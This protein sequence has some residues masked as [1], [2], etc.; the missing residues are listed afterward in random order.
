MAARCVMVL[1]TS[2]GAGKSFL[3]TALC[4]WYANQGL[5]VAPFKAQNMSNNARVVVGRGGEPGEIGAAQYFQALAAGAEPEVRMNPVLLKPE[6]D[7]RSQV[8]VLGRVRSELAAVPWR[9]RSAQLWPAALQALQSLRADHEVVVIEGA[10][11]PAEINLAA[12]DFV[13]TRTARAAQ[14]ACLLV[15]DIDRG[16]AFAHCFGTHA[17]MDAAVRQ[18]LRGFVLNKFRGDASLL[19]PAPQRLQELTGL[20]T[21]AVLPMQRDHGLPEED[22]LHEH[23]PAPAA[24]SACTVAVV[25]PPSASNLDEFQP[26]R[27][28]PGVR[29]VWARDAAAA[30]ADWLVLPGSKHTRADL[31]WL[32]E[33]GLDRAIAAHVQAGRPLLG[34]CGGLQMLGETLDDPQGVEGGTPGRSE[35]LGLLP[36]ATRFAPHKTLRRGTH[37]LRPLHGPWAALSGLALQ[38]YEIHMGR[39][40]ATGD[41]TEVL[42]G[43]AWQRGPVLGVYLHGLFENPAV[44]HALFGSAPRPLEDSFNRLADSVGACFTRDTLLSLL[45]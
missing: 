25:V 41:A 14:A 32:R 19:A 35:G 23:F 39:T 3:A 7:T 27:S 15:A 24:G 26:L 40:H 1:G 30:Q 38:G 37:T 45:E 16:G 2:S 18:Q 9:E 29:L 13:N 4:R 33:R 5:R 11:S 10:G 28:L 34:V 36:L 17:L 6:A 20:P 8:V 22:G 44:L 42:P 31:Q 43:L 12:E 21:L